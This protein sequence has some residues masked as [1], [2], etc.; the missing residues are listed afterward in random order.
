MSLT[1]MLMLVLTLTPR[2]AAVLMHNVFS[3]LLR[4]AYNLA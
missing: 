1:L 3:A 2:V 4:Y